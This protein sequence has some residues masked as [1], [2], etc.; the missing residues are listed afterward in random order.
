M[1]EKKY[2]SRDIFTLTNEEIVKLVDLVLVDYNLDR[3]VHSLYQERPSLNRTLVYRKIEAIYGYYEFA[4]VVKITLG[5]EDLDRKIT[6]GFVLSNEG[7]PRDN[8]IYDGDFS[9]GSVM[10]FYRPF[11]DIVHQSGTGNGFGIDFDYSHLI[12]Y[13]KRLYHFFNETLRFWSSTL[14][15][16]KYQYNQQLLDLGKANMQDFVI[17]E[18]DI[19]NHPERIAL[20]SK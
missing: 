12:V 9:I 18:V 13:T 11:Q 15:L 5:F 4:Y 20:I 14:S 10:G 3:I 19:V 2:Y 8:E 16:D 17:E 6:T 1:E 7:G